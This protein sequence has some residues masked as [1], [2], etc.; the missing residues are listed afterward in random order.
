MILTLIEGNW[1]PAGG[2]ISCQQNAPTSS[3][4]LQ[5]NAAAAAAAAGAAGAGAA[6]GAAAGGAGVPWQVQTL[7]LFP[8]WHV[9]H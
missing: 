9:D 7:L 2:E 5:T 6:A 3:L 8:P 1:L 4:L